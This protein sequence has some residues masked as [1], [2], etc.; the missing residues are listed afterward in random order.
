MSPFE[1]ITV[2]KQR[3]AHGSMVDHYQFPYFSTRSYLQD[4]DSRLHHPMNSRAL[5]FDLFTK[6]ASYPLMVGEWKAESGDML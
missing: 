3:G 5:F 2:L 1:S 4:A 6:D